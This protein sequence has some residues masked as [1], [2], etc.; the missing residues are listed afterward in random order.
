MFRMSS[1]RQKS[2]YKIAITNGIL[3]ASAFVWYQVAFNGLKTLLTDIPESTQLFIFGVNIAS[4]AISGLLAT[5]FIDKFR[6]RRLFLYLW[7]ASGIFLS[8]IPLGLNSANVTELMIISALFGGYFGLG[9]P[10]TMG[11]HSIFLKIEGRAKIG[12]LTFLIIAFIFVITSI[13]PLDSFFYVCLLLVVTRIFALIVFHFIYSKE[14]PSKEVIKVKY[15]S[16]IN[17]RSFLLYF[18]PW[19]MFALINFSLLPIQQSL[20]PPEIDLTFFIALEN[21]ITAFVAVLSGFLADKF[22]RKRLIII[23]FVML[24]IGYAFI[25]LTY[26][27]NLLFGS[28]IYAVTDGAAWGI[29][30]VLFLFTI[31]GDLAQTRNSDKFYFLGALPYLSAY[32]LQI[33]FRPY[34]LKIDPTTIFSFA[35]VF[36]FIAVLP[37]I[38]APETLP[39]K[40]MKDRDLKNYLE[41]AQKIAKKETKKSNRSEIEQEQEKPEES[42]PEINNNKE[43]DEARKLAEKYY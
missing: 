17:N 22:G 26:T 20:Y 34:L 13:V 37:L 30:Y 36:L 6:D 43:Y 5:I 16:V 9:M 4:I 38:Y 41:K 21:V 8:I 2:N 7:I 33:L 42:E 40:I 1:G 15:S 24:G 39:E 32:F 27:S 14:E 23:G 29:F 25:V 18:I 10:V 19:G 28:L 31:W 3:V 35:S 11:Y 12:G